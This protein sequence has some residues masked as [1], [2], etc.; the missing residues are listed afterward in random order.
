MGVYRHARKIWRQIVGQ[1]SLETVAP[2]KFDRSRQ[3]FN[4][5]ELNFFKTV[6]RRPLLETFEQF[7]G[8]PELPTA[9]IGTDKH[10]PKASQIAAA[11]NHPDRSDDLIVGRDGYPKIAFSFLKKL[12]NVLQ[13]WLFGERDRHLKLDLLDLQD[14]F[15]CLAG[16]FFFEYFYLKHPAKLEKGGRLPLKKWNLPSC[17]V[18]LKASAPTKSEI[19]T[20]FFNQNFSKSMDGCFQHDIAGGADSAFLKQIGLLFFKINTSEQS[21]LFQQTVASRQTEFSKNTA[22]WKN[23]KGQ[24]FQNPPRQ[25]TENCQFPNPIG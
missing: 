8:D 11:I 24:F 15:G 21:P 23:Q 3:P 1:N 25:K 20:S 10:L 18:M 17:D 7:L 19:L 13:I 6:F 5:A 22:R 9:K 14:E 16:V 4:R 12:G 2:I